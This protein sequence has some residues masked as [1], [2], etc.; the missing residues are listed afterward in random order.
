MPQIIPDRA[1]FYVFAI[2]GHTLIGNTILSYLGW[3]KNNFDRNLNDLDSV[4]WVVIFYSKKCNRYLKKKLAAVAYKSLWKSWMLYFHGWIWVLD[5]GI[6]NL[7][8]THLVMSW[9]LKNLSFSNL[10]FITHNF[11]LWGLFLVCFCDCYKHPSGF[12]MW[13]WILMDLKNLYLKNLI[14]VDLNLKLFS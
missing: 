11:R 2:K 8:D 3:L 7:W 12:R 14:L 1:D 13:I 4:Y 5:V 10:I 6:C 9:D